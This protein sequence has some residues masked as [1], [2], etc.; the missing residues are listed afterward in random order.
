MGVVTVFSKTV[1][2]IVVCLCGCGMN[3]QMYYTPDTIPEQLILS[4]GIRL[5][6]VKAPNE[7][8]TK[9]MQQLK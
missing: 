4:M 7:T 5:H 2:P 1:M 9:L 3:Y 6:T 8:G